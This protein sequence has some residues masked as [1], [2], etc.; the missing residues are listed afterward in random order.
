MADVCCQKTTVNTMYDK[1]D[2]VGTLILRLD[3]DSIFMYSQGKELVADTMRQR[4]VLTT[5]IWKT[6]I[7]VADL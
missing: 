7:S 5:M 3:A 4:K 6:G 2:C 1:E